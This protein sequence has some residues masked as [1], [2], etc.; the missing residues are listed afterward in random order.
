MQVGKD[1]TSLTITGLREFSIYEVF[2]LAV[3]EEGETS[4]P[5]V[6]MKVVTHVEGEKNSISSDTSPLPQLPDTVACCKAANMT[7]RGCV[8]LV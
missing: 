7:D 1:E 5:S 4:M 2:V 8:D 6:G 3:N